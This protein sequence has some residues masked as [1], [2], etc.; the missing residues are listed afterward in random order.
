MNS[1]CVAIS[2]L[3]VTTGIYG[4]DEFDLLERVRKAFDKSEIWPDTFRQLR[5]TKVVWLN[6]D[7]FA[8]NGSK[9]HEIPASRE[10]WI[11]CLEKMG[12]L[13]LAQLEGDMTD[14]QIEVGDR[15]FRGF[16]PPRYGRT[17]IIPLVN[18]SA[19]L[20]PS[21]YFWFDVKGCGVATGTVPEPTMHRTGLLPLR[22][23]F[24]EVILQR[25]IDG[26]FARTR[27]SSARSS[28][29]RHFKPRLPRQGLFG[30]S[31]N[32]LDTTTSVPPAAAS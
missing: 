25:M 21:R 5:S 8:G 13:S 20:E 22:E 30:R 26:L 10:N 14:D 27:Y 16:R 17:A 32:R 4:E 19:P 29:L 2:D 9:L 23:A 28:D 18:P 7:L 1:N 6:E 11:T 3:A 24:R 12:V 31:G 15:Q